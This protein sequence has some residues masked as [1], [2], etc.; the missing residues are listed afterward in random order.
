MIFW[1]RYAFEFILTIFEKVLAVSQKCQ[2]AKVIRI[3][4]FEEW[5]R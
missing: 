5:F 1:I 4:D 2:D 3:I